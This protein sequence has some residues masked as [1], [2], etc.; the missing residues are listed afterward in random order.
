M[1]GF[2]RE[3][4][5]ET[6]KNRIL[7]NNILAPFDILFRNDQLQIC[8]EDFDVLVPALRDILN[9]VSPNITMELVFREL[10]LNSKSFAQK[11]KDYISTT[12]RTNMIEEQ[13][14]QAD[15][16]RNSD[17]SSMQSKKDSSL[18]M[19]EGGHVFENDDLYFVERYA[20]K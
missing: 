18:F 4:Q 14:I 8:A 11:H 16:V 9:D 13:K 19:K 17:Q 7:K 5:L 3:E 15:L 6:I 10:G 20:K 1:Q 2:D 12:E